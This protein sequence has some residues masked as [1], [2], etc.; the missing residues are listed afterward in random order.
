MIKPQTDL[1]ESATVIEMGNPSQTIWFDQDFVAVITVSSDTTPVIYYYDKSSLEY[2]LAGKTGTLDGIAYVPG[3]VLL[4][5]ESISDTK[6]VYTIGL[7]LDHMSTYVA[8]NT[9]LVPPEEPEEPVTPNGSYGG[10]L[11]QVP[12]ITNIKLSI[13]SNGRFFEYVLAT[14]EDNRC[15]ISIPVDTIGLDKDGK[16][17]TVITM[18]PADALEPLPENYT[19]IGMA[20]DF[21]P[22]GATFAPAVTLTW[23]YIPEELPDNIDVSMLKIAYYDTP[24][25]AWIFLETSID[26]EHNTL[27]AGITHFSTFAVVAQITTEPEPTAPSTPEP[28]ISEK[29]PVTEPEP[30]SAVKP[31]QTPEPIPEE[32]QKPG[33]DIA[34]EETTEPVTVPSDNKVDW[35]LLMVIFSSLILVVLAAGIYLKYKKR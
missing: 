11:P 17:L 22:S 15:A 14:T 20:Y 35:P 16:A 25:G 18:L 31:D 13:M 28:A 26:T 27:T 24:T 7:L 6:N 10:G 3:G 29:T 30:T 1:P 19:V 23:K 8:S 21:G 34:P 32:T 9:N 12:G 5:T 2:E 4:N 33:P